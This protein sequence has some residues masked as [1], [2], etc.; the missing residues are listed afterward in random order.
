MDLSCRTSYSR[1]FTQG[2]KFLIFGCTQGILKWNFQYKLFSLGKESH[3]SSVTK[4]RFKNH[5]RDRTNFKGCFMNRQSMGISSCCPKVFLELFPIIFWILPIKIWIPTVEIY[6]K[7]STRVP[8]SH[9]SHFV[10]IPTYVGPNAS[11]Y[12]CD[13][14][15][16]QGIHPKRIR[17]PKLGTTTY[18][19][20]SKR[21]NSVKSTAFSLISNEPLTK[22]YLK[23][24]AYCSL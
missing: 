11:M 1:N 2:L 19:P 23:L 7:N 17:S 16:H 6:N 10:L 4:L 20:V 5:L 22:E 8:S 21:L 12:F 15:G 3:I 14:S 18:R 24:T 9:I 13:P